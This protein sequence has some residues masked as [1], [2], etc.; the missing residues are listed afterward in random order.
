MGREAHAVGQAAT[1]ESGSQPSPEPGR[2]SG[3]MG[4]SLRREKAERIA[5]IFE[6]KTFTSRD[7]VV[8]FFA[9]V[10]LRH[11]IDTLAQLTKDV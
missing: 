11:E 9:K 1:A 4:K 3:A 8:D 6:N 7:D 10:L 2:Y 5:L